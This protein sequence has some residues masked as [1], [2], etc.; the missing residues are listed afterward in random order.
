MKDAAP[1]FPASHCYYVVAAATAPQNKVMLLF[2]DIAVLD[3]R[4]ID[5]LV[6]IS[7]ARVPGA[8][9]TYTAASHPS[10][11]KTGSDG[12]NGPP[13]YCP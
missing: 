1:A 6:A 10:Y 4:M 9:S 3:L 5:R 11:T 12:K 2:W 13:Q 8:Q 7:L